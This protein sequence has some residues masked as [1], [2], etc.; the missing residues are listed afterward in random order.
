VRNI[1]KFHEEVK[2]KLKEF[3]SKDFE[4]DHSMWST[5]VELLKAEDANE[6]IN[7]ELNTK[8]SGKTKSDIDTDEEE[9]NNM[10]VDRNEEVHE[11]D[12]EDVK[13]KNKEKIYAM[14]DSQK[15]KKETKP[16]ETSNQMRKSNSYDP[17]EVVL[18]IQSR[19]KK[20]FDNTKIVSYH[21]MI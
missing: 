21:L 14:V 12:E 9:D 16:N 6:E 13:D 2:S 5:K 8:K 11:R 1:I 15:K 20:Y 19:Y 18:Y 3:I 7:N 10:D 17:K 4:E